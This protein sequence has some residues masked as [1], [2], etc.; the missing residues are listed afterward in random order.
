M[1]SFNH[2]FHLETDLIYEKHADLFEDQHKDLTQ[3]AARV[4]GREM[5]PILDKN[6][7]LKQSSFNSKAKH[8]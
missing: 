4:I 1:L 6:Q 3:I 8:G 5:K 2:Y 7:L